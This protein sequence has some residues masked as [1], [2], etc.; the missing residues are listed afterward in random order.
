VYNLFTG[1]NMKD[2]F[3]NN[4]SPF[5]NADIYSL[6]EDVN[7]NLDYE[8]ISKRTFDKVNIRSI[9]SIKSLFVNDK[10][11]YPLLYIIRQMHLAGMDNN[12]IFNYVD[13]YVLSI[14]HAREYYEQI[15][16]DTITLFKKYYSDSRIIKLLNTSIDFIKDTIY[17]LKVISEHKEFYPAKKPKSIYDL[18][19]NVT[20]L[21]EKIDIGNLEL[22]QRE[23]VLKLQGKLPAHKWAGL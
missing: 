15:T 23:D 10:V 3:L 6:L 18:H 14:D 1:E 2:N 21:S 20:E 11:N 4:Q 17:S 19:N 16:P 9:D 5:V 13:N 7:S 22:N 8:K 12:I